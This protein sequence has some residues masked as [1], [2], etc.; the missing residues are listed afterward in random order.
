MSATFAKFSHY[1]L[2]IEE[3][4]IKVLEKY[5]VLMYD[6]LSVTAFVDDARLLS[7]FMKDEVL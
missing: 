6:L 3:S 7:H 2:E 5:V 4:D 1:T